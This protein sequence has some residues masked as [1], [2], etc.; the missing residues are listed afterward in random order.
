MAATATDTQL[1]TRFRF[2][3]LTLVRQLRH[4]N[5]DLTASQA[6]ALAS[7]ARLGPM[8][9]GDLAKAEH[10]S[11]PMVT[12]IAKGLEEERL[13]TRTPDDVDKRVVRLAI[14]KEGQRRLER[15]R[16]QKNAWLAR[17]FRAL[18]DE[19]LAAIEAVI[20]VLERITGQ[21]DPGA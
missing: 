7:I 13:V 4:H 11:S 18:S 6:S 15:S 20:P 14:T 2:A 10:V 16:S 12:K 9:V 21:G 19:D 8:T 5:V 1:A 17:Q 3:L